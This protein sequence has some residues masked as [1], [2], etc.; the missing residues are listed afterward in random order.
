M[1]LPGKVMDWNCSLH[2]LQLAFGV[3]DFLVCS[4]NKFHRSNLLMSVDTTHVVYGWQVISP[5][6]ASG[7]VLDAP[8]ASK[9]LSSVA[10][11]LSNCS[12]SALAHF[13]FFCLCLLMFFTP[14]TYLIILGLLHENRF[15]RRLFSM[16]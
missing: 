15:F 11:A 4:W 7:V 13:L 14:G 6:S 5:Q 1:V 3:K 9:L 8:E 10:I 16:G 12:R 2:D